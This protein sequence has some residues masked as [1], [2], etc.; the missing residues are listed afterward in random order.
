MNPI[1]S[2]DTV[3]NHGL[4]SPDKVINLDVPS[5]SNE[6]QDKSVFGLT[7]S[8]K[9]CCREFINFGAYLKHFK[10]C[11]KTYVCLKCNVKFK[12]LKYL[13]NHVKSKHSEAKIPCEH[14]DMKFRSQSKLDSHVKTHFKTTVSVICPLCTKVFKSSNVLRVHKSMKHSKKEQAKPLKLWPCSLC[15]KVFKS[16]RGLR[17]HKLLHKMADVTTEEVE[18]QVVFEEQVVV[19]E[20]AVIEE[21]AL[22]YSNIVISDLV[23]NIVM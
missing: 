4:P 10:A 3:S 16:D 8:C 18:E 19:E 13:K 20:Q 17:G 2:S 14:C 6:P 5:S 21:Q 9:T 1:I 11:Q 15:P 12:K 7:K 23:D 22:G